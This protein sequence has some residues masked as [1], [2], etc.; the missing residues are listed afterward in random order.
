MYLSP[1]KQFLC[2]VLALCLVTTLILLSPDSY[3]PVAHAQEAKKAEAVSSSSSSTSSP[4]A[5]MTARLVASFPGYEGPSIL[6]GRL[7]LVAFSP[8]G[9]VLALSGSERVIKLFDVATGKLIHTLS[10]TQKLGINS[11]AFSPDGRT[12]MTRDAMDRSVRIWDLASGEQKLLLIGRKKNFETKLKAGG[13]PS[14]EYMGVGLSPDG[15]T[16]LVEREDDIVALFDTTTRQEKALLNH[17][18][19]SSTVKTVLAFALPLGGPMY[20]LHMRPVYSPDSRRI[21]T[22]N[23][24]ASPKLW[25]GKT[26]LL[27]AKLEGH[28]DRV[29]KGLF[30]PDSS[31]LATTSIGGKT[32]LW[33]AGT[34][35]LKVTLKETSLGMK[36]SP[37][38]Q[39][40]VTYHG[41]E[42]KL[43]DARTGELKHTLKKARTAS[44]AFSPGSRLLATDGDDNTAAKL[45]DTTTGQLVRE[46]PRPDKETGHVEFSPDGRLLVTTSDAGIRLWDAVSGQLLV[47]LDKARF[48]LRFSPNGR[49][50][51]TGGTDKMAHL[52]ELM[53][54]Q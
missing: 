33:D 54:G 36:F 32:N 22:V 23:G 26:G 6:S 37:D 27:I 46:L 30:S 35:Q 20:I 25:D 4:Q 50:L 28:K 31:L 45:W 10:T 49:F 14:D 15:Q 1:R 17:Q 38:S 19:E 2:V 13:L 9:R 34:G 29:Y 16:L 42:T 41:R 8:D 51:A 40:L 21:V 5:K 3:A 24:D 53:S 12:A 44:V 43:W 18:T 7:A 11:F 52:Y 48:P 47:T 39:T